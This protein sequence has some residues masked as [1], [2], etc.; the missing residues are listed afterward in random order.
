VGIEPEFPNTL[1][2]TI[3][4]QILLQIIQA[5]FAQSTDLLETLV[6][7]I[8]MAVQQI[9]LNIKYFFISIQKT[10]PPLGIVC[11]S[12]EIILEKNY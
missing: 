4:Y 9:F 7:N 12:S 8:E 3:D 5:H 2:N 1:A 6:I 10:N 11:K